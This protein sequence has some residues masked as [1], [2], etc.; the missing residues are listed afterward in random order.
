MQKNLIFSSLSILALSLVTATAH[1]QWVVHATAGTLKS[2]NAQT[3]VLYVNGDDG[4]PA[5]FNTGL[6]SSD[7]FEFDPH[8]RSQTTPA[9]AYDKVGS[10]VV[11][12]YYGYGTDLT[13]IS[14]ESLGDGTFTTVTG[15]VDKFD[16]HSRTLTIKTDKG[17]DANF[18]VQDNAVIDTGT[19]VKEG[20]KFDPHKGDPVRVTYLASDKGDVQAVFVQ[21]NGY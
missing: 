10:H 14:V 13:A 7:K 18:H 16:K 8:L 21:R 19:G 11:V 1:A 3:K 20:T 4:T 17:T 2:I 15:N 6:K 12:F 9:T 5:K